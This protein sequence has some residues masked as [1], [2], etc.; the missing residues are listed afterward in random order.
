MTRGQ[1]SP[2]LRQ[3]FLRKKTATNDP[4]FTYHSVKSKELDNHD[5]LDFADKCSRE[6]MIV[7][8]KKETCLVPPAAGSGCCRVES[9]T[10]IDARGQMVIP[11]ETRERAGFAAGDRLAVISF[12][13][14]GK[15]CCIC[16]VKADE[17]AGTIRE[18]LGPMLKET[19]GS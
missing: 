3:E 7:P 8:K 18:L 10:T 2:R 19:T 4:T 1:P 13:Q 6:V 15:P 9:V 14:E 17:F 5:Y 11:K 16:L 12:E